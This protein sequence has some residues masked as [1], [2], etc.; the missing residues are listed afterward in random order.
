[1]TR[2]AHRGSGLG[3]G[4][5]LGITALLVLSG[6][7]GTAGPDLQGTVTLE[8]DPEE[9]A[10]V[11]QDLRI[12]CDAEHI[13][14]EDG[15]NVDYLVEPG[16]PLECTVTGLAADVDATW[17][18]QLFDDDIADEERPTHA[19]EGVLT[20]AGGEATFT[21]Q[22]PDEPPLMWLVTE[23]SQG[24]RTA[25]VHGHTHW[26]WVAPMT[27]LPDPATE[28]DTVECRAEGMQPDEQFYW[29]VMLDDHAGETVIWLD[30]SSTTDSSGGAEFAFEV[31]TG[32]PTVRYHADASQRYDNARF[33]G[34][35]R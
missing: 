6:C 26:Y 30:G 32:E 19:L 18:A 5:T 14:H 9:S 8:P 28:G 17:Y 3:Q 15:V 11:E 7:G 16:S 10:A 4:L 24:D 1:V 34:T 13:D 12:V 23:V 27:C 20:V 29:D 33:E 22:V 31:P 2:Q 25:Y 21:T 35:I